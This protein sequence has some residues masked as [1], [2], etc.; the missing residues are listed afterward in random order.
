MFFVNYKAAKELLKHRLI[1]AAIP[2][3]RSH[4]FESPRKLSKGYSSLWLRDRGHQIDL[5]DFQWEWGGDA[6][7][8]IHFRDI[9]HPDDLR[10]IREFPNKATPWDFGLS[11]SMAKGKWRWFAPRLSRRFA[12]FISKEID[13]VIGAVC[14]RIDEIA[15][16]LEGGQPSGYFRDDV[17]WNDKRLPENPPPWTEKAPGSKYHLPSYRAGT[18]ENPWGKGP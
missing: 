4:G 3:L 8:Q 2:K 1:A 12:P 9:T 6:A 5:F 16:F 15:A 14:E 18:C 17:S 13:L 7:F 11:A 10:L